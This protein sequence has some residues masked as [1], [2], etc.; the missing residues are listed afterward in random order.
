MPGE[1]TNWNREIPGWREAVERE[2]AVRDE[3]FLGLTE[4]LCGIEVLPLSAYHFLILEAV[5]SP[6]V[7]GGVPNEVD[8]ARFLW[9]VSPQFRPTT[10]RADRKLRDKFIRRLSNLDWEQSVKAITT[11]TEDAFQ[12]SPGS[13][14]GSQASYWSWIAGLVDF[15]AS[16]YGWTERDIIDIPLKRAFQYVRLIKSRESEAIHFNRSDTVRGEWL[17]KVNEKAGKN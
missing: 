16:A 2:N 15:I 9:I 5:H 11:Y 17:R 3:S 7:C 4:T 13:R 8:I 14:G 6:F 1:P 10:T 12:D